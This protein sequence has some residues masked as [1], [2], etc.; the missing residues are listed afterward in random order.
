[1]ESCLMAS[2]EPAIEKLPVETEL[3]AKVRIQTVADLDTAVADMV[4]D[5][6]HRCIYLYMGHLN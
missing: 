6:P 4:L 3:Q 2:L 1:M 5:F